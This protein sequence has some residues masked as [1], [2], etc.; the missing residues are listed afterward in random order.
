MET[1]GVEPR[2]ADAPRHTSTCLASVFIYPSSHPKAGKISGEP[3]LSLAR[4]RSR[5][6]WSRDPTF[7]SQ[8]YRG[9]VGLTSL[10]GFFRPLQRAQHC[11]WQL[12]FSSRSDAVTGTRGMQRALPCPRREPIRPLKRESPVVSSSPSLRCQRTS[13]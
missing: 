3:R 5:R 9:P 10:F 7:L 1:L 6:T 13:C 12:C 8:S 4:P 2:S 11:R